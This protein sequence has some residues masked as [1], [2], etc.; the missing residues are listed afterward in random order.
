M[1]RAIKGTPKHLSATGELTSFTYLMINLPFKCNYR[2]SKCFNLK[3]DNQDTSENEISLDERV[4][5]IHE[6]KY[7][8]GKA[9]VMAGEGEPAIHEDI[10]HLVSE[11]SIL[12]MIPIIYTNG[13]TLTEK[14]VSFY[15][16]NSTVLIIAF[17]SLNPELYGKMTG[18]EGMF[19]RV[20]ENIRRT[21]RSYKNMIYFQGSTQILS[22]GINITASTRNE[23]EIERIK[24]FWSDDVYF[25]CN[26][27][28]K[29]GNAVDNWN[30]L[31]KSE[32]N[33]E[34]HRK[35]IERLSESG[36]PLT[37]GNDGICGYSRWGISISPSGDYMTCAYIR[38]TDGLLGN[39]K[40]RSLREAFEYKHKIESEHYKKHGVANCLVRANSFNA[41]LKRL[42]L[43]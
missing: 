24:E 33:P 1:M 42:R 19:E 32:E 22:I 26:P 12:G 11:I 2:C 31:M 43:D 39:I 40:N 20:V 9:V 21:I 37:L 4:R 3:S 5:L 36:G 28:A 34:K 38:A 15:K 25:I 8:G 29:L 35:L 23:D 6:A 27:L 13:S 30:K 17:D 18:T 10:Y 14:R 41:Y 16:D 7:L